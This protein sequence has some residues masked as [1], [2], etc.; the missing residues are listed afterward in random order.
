MKK[1]KWKTL[2]ITCLV[3]I[4]PI[5]LGLTVYDKLP[6]QVA[7]HF[8]MNNNPDNFASRPFAVFVIPLLMLPLQIYCCVLNDLLAAKYGE[9]KK[10]SLVTKWI[11]PMLSV[12]LYTTTILFALGSALDI[13]RIAIFIVG[14]IFIVIGNYMPKFDHI[15]VMGKTKKVEGDKAR[16]IHRFIGYLTVIMGAIHLITLFFPPIASIISLFL[17]IPYAI[18]CVVYGIK[19]GKSK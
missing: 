9:R 3:C 4:A 11:I 16:K 14:M 1:I 13:R 15:Q 5:L 18:L 8:D 17:M 7:I 12:I 19:I 2:I 10:F 6:E